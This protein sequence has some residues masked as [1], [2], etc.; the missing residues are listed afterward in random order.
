M[1]VRFV[2]LTALVLLPGSLLA[3]FRLNLK[4]LTW[5][6]FILQPNGMIIQT[7]PDG[8]QLYQFE[9]LVVTA[10]PHFKLVTGP[11]VCMK[12]SG[13]GVSLATRSPIEIT[14]IVLDPQF[15]GNGFLEFK[16]LEDNT[17]FL[18]RFELFFDTGHVAVEPMQGPLDELPLT[19]R[20]ENI[21]LSRL[22]E[23]YPQF[24]GQLAGLATGSLKMQFKDGS[25]SILDGNIDLQS[26][27]EGFLRYDDAGQILEGM[28]PD[29]PQYKRTVKV[30]RALSNGLQLTR[31]NLRVLPESNTEEIARLNIYGVEKNP[32][33][34]EIA[35][36]ID[37]TVNFRVPADSQDY[38]RSLLPEFLRNLIPQSIEVQ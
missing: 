26:N 24:T 12:Q 32:P 34:G 30:V 8:A 5:G 25:L 4:N 6:D 28:P 7:L 1:R 15:K 17:M 2:I 20:F 31:F 16:L 29:S 38:L 35:E 19:L 37:Y 9:K 13:L 36:Q 3:A 18:Q 27:V 21:D 10:A 14:E 22:A 23:E 33:K 11:V